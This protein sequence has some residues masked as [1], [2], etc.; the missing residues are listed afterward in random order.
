M[1]SRIVFAGAT[2]ALLLALTACA[3]PAADTVADDPTTAPETSAT[4]PSAQAPAEGS[5]PETFTWDHLTSCHQIG[6]PVVEYTAGL[7]LVDEYFSE[8]E[9]QCDWEHPDPV[10]WEDLRTVSISFAVN[11]FVLT[12]DQLAM[13][14]S[15]IAHPDAALEALGGIAYSMDMQTAIT[16]VTGTVVSVPGI[17]VTVSAS[18][19]V[20]LPPLRDATAIA[21]AKQL[22]GI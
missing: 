14:E 5:A 7:T 4:E 16:G 9:I 10:E 17:D 1:T 21:V 12:H 19:F 8:Y 6:A 3:T 15:L 2:A 20:E 13:T 22:L 11:E 18:E